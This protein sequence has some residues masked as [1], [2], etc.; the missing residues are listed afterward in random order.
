MEHGSM[1]G[2]N[3]G[4]EAKAGAASER[5]GKQVREAKVD[6]YKLEYF[7]IDMKESMKGM[8]MQGHDMSKM[9]SHHLMVY[10]AGP[11]GKAVTEGKV[12]YLVA[13]PDKAE[14]KTMAMFMDGGFGA[15][16]DLKAKGAYKVTTKA[17]VGDKTLVDDFTYS[18]K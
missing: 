10:L 14:Q 15:D 6:G 12:G 18:V 9:K 17:V 11:D 2:M 4:G 13:G 3:M 7:L 5:H 1:G 16:V 8:P